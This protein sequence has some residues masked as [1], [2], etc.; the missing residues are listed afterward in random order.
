MEQDNTHTAHSDGAAEGEAVKQDG[1]G[2]KN[3]GMA[4]IAYLIFFVPLLTE[5][6]QDPFVIF[7]VKQG[8]ALFLYWVGMAVLSMIPILGIIVLIGYPVGLVLLIIG[9][10]NASQGKE[11]ELPLI[12]QFAHQFKF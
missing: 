7:H 12:G 2:K 1:G 4:I 3:V 6:K 10:I 9:F 11:K 8:L 5:A